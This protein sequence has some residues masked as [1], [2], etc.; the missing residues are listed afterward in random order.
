M[1]GDEGQ[2][3]ELIRVV[4]AVTWARS[5]AFAWLPWLTRLKLMALYTACCS[6]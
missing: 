1:V 3:S 6:K 2:I 4:I 5:P